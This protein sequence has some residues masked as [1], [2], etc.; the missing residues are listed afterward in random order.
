MSA[1]NA[2]PVPCRRSKMIIVSLPLV[3]PTLSMSSVAQIQGGSHWVGT[4]RRGCKR[5]SR[6]IHRLKLRIHP[7]AAGSSGRCHA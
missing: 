1:P 2:Q 6:P 3:A 7:P 5:S 4:W